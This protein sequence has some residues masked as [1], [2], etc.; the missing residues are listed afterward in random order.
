M[1][2][3]SDVGDY[4][5][6]EAE[7]VVALSDDGGL[8]SPPNAGGGG[9]GGAAAGNTAMSTQGSA[10]TGGSTDDGTPDRRHD[11]SHTPDHGNLS[12]MTDGELTNSYLDVMVKVF[13]RANLTMDQQVGGGSGGGKGVTA[14]GTTQSVCF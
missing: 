5:T 1:E 10:A 13:E 14:G 11:S 8:D 2:S 12:S 4:L 7:D 9:S 6:D 3:T